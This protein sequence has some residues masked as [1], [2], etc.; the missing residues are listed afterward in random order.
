MVFVDFQNFEKDL[1][2]AIVCKNCSISGKNTALQTAVAVSV[3]VVTCGCGCGCGLVAVGPKT[4]TF[5]KL[6]SHVV[7]LIFSSKSFLFS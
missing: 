5:T 1:K 4:A 2:I 7:L 3:A 6:N